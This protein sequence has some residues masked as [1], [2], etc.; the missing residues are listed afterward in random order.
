MDEE[1][2]TS[3]DLRIADGYLIRKFGRLKIFVH[4]EGMGRGSRRGRWQ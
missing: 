1:D 3:L 2:P 4:Y